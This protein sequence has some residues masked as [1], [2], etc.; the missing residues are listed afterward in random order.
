MQ[1]EAAAH[2]QLHKHAVH[3]LALALHLL[4]LQTGAGDGRR[5]ADR[6]VLHKWAGAGWNFAA[7]RTVHRR[8][9][10]AVPRRRCSHSRLACSAVLSRPATLWPKQHHTQ[11]KLQAGEGAVLVRVGQRAGCAAACWAHGLQQALLLPAR[12]VPWVLPLSTGAAHPGRTTRLKR[13]QLATISTPPSP[14]R[15]RQKRQATSCATAAADACGSRTRGGAVAGGR[16][17]RAAPAP[18]AAS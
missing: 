3:R 11:L 6:L 14:A 1:K 9:L 16:R 18:L 7:L 5:G 15:R 10:R 4:V 8:A 13:P 2:H 12:P 17:R